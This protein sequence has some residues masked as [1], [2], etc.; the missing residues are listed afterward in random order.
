VGHPQMLGKA[1]GK[2]SLAAPG[3]AEDHESSVHT[4]VLPRPPALRLLPQAV[5][6]VDEGPEFGQRARTV[7]GR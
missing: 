6:I 5:R 3:G 1:G 2:S 4:P 7:T